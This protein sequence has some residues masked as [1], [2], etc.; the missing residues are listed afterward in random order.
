MPAAGITGSNGDDPFIRR[1]L[2]SGTIDPAVLT[3]FMRLRPV[4][5]QALAEEPMARFW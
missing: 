1:R 5:Q 2:L 3:S 4:W